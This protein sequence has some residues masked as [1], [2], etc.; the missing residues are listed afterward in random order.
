MTQIFERESIIKLFDESL[1]ELVAIACDY[2]VIP[3]KEK[4]DMIFIF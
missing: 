2:D 1:K 4:R 3:H